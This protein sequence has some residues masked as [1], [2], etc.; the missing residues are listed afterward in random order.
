[1][2]PIG[3]SDERHRVRIEFHCRVCAVVNCLGRAKGCPPRWPIFETLALQAGG[4]D[5]SLLGAATSGGGVGVFSALADGGY[6]LQRSAAL[7]APVTSAA[8]DASFCEVTKTPTG[9]M[10]ARLM[11]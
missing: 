1:V 11:H 2:Y 10:R 8:F 6:A 4:A 3:F 9:V 7:N 5:G